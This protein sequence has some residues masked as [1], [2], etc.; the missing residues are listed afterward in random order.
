[1]NWF[2]DLQRITTSPENAVRIMEAMANIDVM[3]VTARE[4]A[5]ARFA[6]PP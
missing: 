6:L 5:D 4:R 2:N 1:M 3:V